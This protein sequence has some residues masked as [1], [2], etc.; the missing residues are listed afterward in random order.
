MILL[1]PVEVTVGENK[2]YI[3]KFPALKAA[4]VLGKLNT[5]L[6]PIASGLVPLVGLASKGDGKK[7]SLFDADISKAIP[8]LTNA[9]VSLDGDSLQNTLELLLLKH[10][11]V[12]IEYTDNNGNTQTEKLNRDLID[13]VFCGDLQDLFMLAYHV[14]SINYGSFFAKALTQFGNP[15]PK[16]E[17]QKKSKS[18]V[19]S[20]P[21]NLQ[22]LS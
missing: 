5:V 18:T 20:T 8:L 7:A 15:S 6:S 4:N 10:N 14:I 9:L 11:N 16:Q 22:T 17:T 19:S 3:L 2:F 12:T 13:S 21:R 1:E